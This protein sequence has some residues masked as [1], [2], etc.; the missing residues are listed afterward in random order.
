MLQ[1][2]NIHAILGIHP[3]HQPH[4]CC[5]ASFQSF[6]F[7]I[8]FGGVDGSAKQMHHLIPFEFTCW[9]FLIY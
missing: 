6:C 4:L 9:F 2:Q 3:H 5:L 7:S 1:T 8:G